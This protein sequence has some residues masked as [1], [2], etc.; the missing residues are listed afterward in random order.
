M[1]CSLSIYVIHVLDGRS[2]INCT[3]IGNLYRITKT[4]YS[5]DNSFPSIHWSY[6]HRSKVVH[7]HLSRT[8]STERI[9]HS[10]APP[11]APKPRLQTPTPPQAPPTTSSEPPALPPRHPLPLPSRG[12]SDQARQNT[13][14]VPTGSQ[15]FQTQ[16]NSRPLHPLPDPLNTRPHGRPKSPA[17]KPIRGGKILCSPGGFNKTPPPLFY[18]NRGGP[19]GSSAS[20]PPQT[21]GVKPQGAHKV[22]VKPQGAHKV[23][24][25]PQGAHKV[26]VKPQGAHKT[27]VKPQG[28]HKTGVK[29]Q[30]AHKVGGRSAA[31]CEDKKEFPLSPVVGGASGAPID[32]DRRPPAPL[33]PEV[34]VCVC[35][36][37]CACVCVCVCVGACVLSY[38]LCNLNML[39]CVCVCVSSAFHIV[40]RH[41]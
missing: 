2:P 37:V 12:L 31:V 11:T 1:P 4:L 3:C 35:V 6:I 36:R 16:S 8:S 26:G 18:G 24:V 19:V 10:P 30:G 20:P 21:S 14:T 29:P 33:P 13:A 41:S 5:L 9:P 40:C 25:K 39:V 15:G 17:L 28:A 27:G 22:G 32:I 34:C 38:R 7:P 23:G